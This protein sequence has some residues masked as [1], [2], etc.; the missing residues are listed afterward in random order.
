MALREWA[1]LIHNL[2]RYMNSPT[3]TMVVQQAE[4]AVEVQIKFNSKATPKG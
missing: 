1:K 2:M 4:V 3:I